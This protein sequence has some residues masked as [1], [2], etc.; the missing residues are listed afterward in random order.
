MISADEA[1]FP[2]NAVDILA[3]RFGF[4]DSAGDLKVFR[5]P[6]RDT[7]PV[8]SVGV[9]GAL[10]VP[11]EESYEMKGMGSPAPQEPT[12]QKYSIAIQAFV[13]DMEEERGLAT[14][15]VLS[16]MI[17]A[18][19]Y[20]DEPLRIGLAGLQAT[21][22]GVTERTMRWGV[23]TQRFLNNELDSAWLYL[24]TVEFWLETRIT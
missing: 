22:L 20:R 11:D 16:K 13:K 5:R 21:T 8:Q 12:I 23:T 18:M 6:L 3:T 15:S 1:V 7:D 24:S 4:L 14:H 17:L 2:N 9:F 19:L 10:W